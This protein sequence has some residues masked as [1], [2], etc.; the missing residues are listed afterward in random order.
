MLKQQGQSGHPRPLR[1]SSPKKCKNSAMWAAIL[2]HLDHV[3]RHSVHQIVKFAG[4]PNAQKI[5]HW[6][7]F[8]FS[9]G[10]L[11][12]RHLWSTHGCPLIP[13]FTIS[14]ISMAFLCFLN[15]SFSKEKMMARI[16]FF[17]PKSSPEISR[18]GVR[19]EAG[20]GVYMQYRI[21]TMRLGGGG[22]GQSPP[23]FFFSSFGPQLR[24]G[25]G[26]SPGSATVNVLPSYWYN[27]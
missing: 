4:R 2:G 1:I 7:C 14:G 17:H 24:G 22:V 3:S 12:S 23:Q 25:L 5:E 9:S 19:S 13:S 15:N 27:V 18:G 6:Y 11:L 21:Q 10:A 16:Y 26:P 8:I 20:T